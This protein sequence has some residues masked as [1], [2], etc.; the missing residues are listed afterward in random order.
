MIYTIL[1]ILTLIAI[2]LSLYNVIILSFSI[3]TSL[4]HLYRY[5]EIRFAKGYDSIIFFQVFLYTLFSIIFL[6]NLSLKYNEILVNQ[7][8][9]LLV[10][11][12]LVFIGIILV[13]ALVRYKRPYSIIDLYQNYSSEVTK[14]V[15]L[16]EPLTNINYPKIDNPSFGINELGFNEIIE[17]NLY[18]KHYLIKDLNED[19]IKKIL[20][21]CK[22]SAESVLLFKKIVECF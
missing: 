5:N 1:F 9:D 12:I 6:Y 8:N 16:L 3:F 18:K 19:E 7:N 14:D 2:L 13:S 17:R 11:Y 21:S 15:D 10:S 20:N 4:I 22:S